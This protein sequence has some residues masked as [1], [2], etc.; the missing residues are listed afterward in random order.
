MVEKMAK[1]ILPGWIKRV[2]SLAA[3]G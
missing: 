1:P 3:Y 2:R